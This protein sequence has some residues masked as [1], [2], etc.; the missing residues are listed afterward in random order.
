MLRSLSAAPP[1]K[2]GERFR[3]LDVNGD[4]ILTPQELK[5]ARIFQLLDTNSDGRVE[6]AEARKAVQAGALQGVV[7]DDSETAAAGSP[8]KPVADPGPI[9]RGPARLIPGD[10]GVGRFVPE[11]EFRTLDGMVHRLSEFADRQAL[12]VAMTSTSCPLSLKYLPTLK[13]LADEFADQ[14]VAFVLVNPVDVDKAADMQEAQRQLGD[15]AVYVFDPQ[16]EL[17]RAVNAQTT[18]D[19]VVMDASRTV[20][21]HGA[22][23]D[24]YG[25]GYSIDE[26]R[27]RYLRDALTA[28]LSGKA[29]LVEATD[30][31]GCALDLGPVEP[32]SAGV[33]YHREISRLI[34]RHCIECHRD[35]GVAPFSLE[36]YDDVVGHAPMIRE[37][38]QRGLMPP[39]F[40]A[41]TED[42]KPGVSGK[43][44]N[45]RSLAESEKQTLLSWVAAGR[46][47][48]DPKDA[49]AARTF[50]DGWLIGKPDAVFGFPKAQRIKATGTMPYQNIRVETDLD[51]DKWVQAI[52]VR[53]GNRAVVHHVIVSIRS[54]RNRDSDEPVDPTEDERQGFWGIYVPGNS[55]LIY[56]DGYAK[57]LPK[58]A[59]LNF[60][61]HYTP[62]GT[63][64]E[65]LTEMGIVFAK[66]PPQ[67]EIRVAGILNGRI[68]IPAGADNHPETA[69]LRVPA[70]VQVLAFLPHMHLR[71][72]AARYD[73]VSA[74]GT[75]TV[76]DIP[77][78]DFN[79]QLLYR[80]AEP[81]NVSRGD[82]IRFTGW[83]D[84]SAANPANPDPTINVKWGP[85]TFDEM[86]LGY[87]EYVVP[88]L[89]LGKSVVELRPE[90]LREA[91]RQGDQ[92]FRRLDADGDNKLT[93]QEV[94]NPAG[95]GR[96]SLDRLFKRLDVDA[97]GDLTREELRELRKIAAERR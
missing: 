2:L 46:P 3:Q 16:Q 61:M 84:N 26:P 70:D 82:T 58:G 89:H 35:G 44:L 14:G 13:S 29:P 6:F 94:N 71:G 24:Q 49:P 69:S 40:A 91:A 64:T 80:L 54:G 66:S 60:Q 41:D 88:E 22:V 34:Q 30:A 75:Q 23:D 1:A 95:E 8:P 42:R 59:T 39:W 31:P 12:V 57:K 68:N 56:P 92:L 36:T 74:G 72:K 77:R 32:N 38:L 27:E 67:H 19:V 65:D 78:Y 50:S 81:M 51:E 11:T 73:V 28:L 85:Q 4:N 97:S 79:W 48:G 25:F 43:W 83:F 76:L 7:E 93:L 96:R 62:N 37:V 33:T 47:E 5:D 53:P 86:L 87:V 17:A 21:Y 9:R 10:H 15:N 18:T 63:A 45:D 55:T 90:Q 20:V 52:E